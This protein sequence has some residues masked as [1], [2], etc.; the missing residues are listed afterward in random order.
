MRETAKASFAFHSAKAPTGLLLL[1]CL[2]QI[3]NNIHGASLE[4]LEGL[5]AREEEVGREWEWLHDV[6]NRVAGPAL[7][8]K[9]H[10]LFASYRSRRALSA[11][12]A[13]PCGC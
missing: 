13:W 5:Q 11:S 3:E 7:I 1:H 10:M 8:R 2:E 6:I 4:S 9:T 12:A